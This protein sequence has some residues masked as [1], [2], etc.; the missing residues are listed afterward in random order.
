[1]NKCKIAARKIHS[2]RDEKV[3]SIGAESARKILRKIKSKKYV[4]SSKQIL[5]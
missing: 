2:Y 5:N 1:M 3:L 4:Y